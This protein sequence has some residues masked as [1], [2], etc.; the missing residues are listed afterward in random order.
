[1][2]KAKRRK[3]QREY[4]LYATHRGGH[5]SVYSVNYSRGSHAWTYHVYA[6]SVRQAY[7]LASNE[8]FATGPD[9]VGVRVIENDWWHG[10]CDACNQQRGCPDHRIVAPYLNAKEANS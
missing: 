2:P 8:I 3:R 7:Y 10:G 5:F 1:M 4:V 6:A 9:A